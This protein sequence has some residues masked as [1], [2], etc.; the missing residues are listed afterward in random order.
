MLSA[1]VNS[2]PAEIEAALPV[3]RSLLL[4]LATAL[5]LRHSLRLLSGLFAHFLCALPLVLFSQRFESASDGDIQPATRLT[6]M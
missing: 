4:L 2:S 3:S 6:R 5:M 1:G